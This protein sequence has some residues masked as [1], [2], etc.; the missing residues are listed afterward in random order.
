MHGR[1]LMSLKAAGELQSR[2][3]HSPLQ[4]DIF[5]HAWSLD[6]RAAVQIYRVLLSVYRPCL[7]TVTLFDDA[8]RV[9]L[10]AHNLAHYQMR[11]GST[12]LWGSDSESV[13]PQMASMSLAQK[14][15]QQAE[16]SRGHRYNAV[17]RWRFDLVPY[18]PVHLKLLSPSLPSRP[19]HQLE[20]PA[21][22]IFFLRTPPTIPRRPRRAPISLRALPPTDL[23]PCST[24]F[25]DQA[26]Y[27]SSETMDALIDLQSE[28]AHASLVLL[29]GEVKAKEGLAAAAVSSKA[30]W[31]PS[32]VAARLKEELE[33]A[34]DEIRRMYAR[35]KERP[36][37]KH[38][39]F[40][41][42]AWGSPLGQEL[43]FGAALELRGRQCAKAP[44]EKPLMELSELAHGGDG[45]A[46]PITRWHYK[47]DGPPSQSTMTSTDESTRRDGAFFELTVRMHALSLGQARLATFAHCRGNPA[48]Q[49][50]RVCRMIAECKPSQQRG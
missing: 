27:G 50:G 7:L 20:L 1:P 11:D 45:C 46:R 31:L 16:K 18:L 2:N 30:F 29:R 47:L 3:L 9:W 28:A 24:D 39:R 15:R 5:I 12:R 48:F 49:F 22:V 4:A 25:N 23:I 34:P 21:K 38:V 44:F 8:A 42:V 36:H 13:L 17:M 32:S 19:S 26:F 35:L 43:L 6:A 41:Y 37:D 10:R 40:R 33:T 14:L